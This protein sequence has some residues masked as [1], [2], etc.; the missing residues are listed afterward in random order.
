M[1]C[2][3]IACA[4]VYMGMC[5]IQLKM[6]VQFSDNVTHNIHA[7]EYVAL[8][9][10]NEPETAY[11]AYE[12]PEVLKYCQ[13]LWR[14]AHKLYATLCAYCCTM[15]TYTWTMNYLYMNASLL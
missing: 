7:Y 15:H 13:L 1:N 14:F 10:A 4:F 2:S 6:F 5:S 3:R 8:M 9:K 11:D 12:T